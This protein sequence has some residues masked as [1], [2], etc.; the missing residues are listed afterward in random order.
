ML[1]VDSESPVYVPATAAQPWQHL[2]ARDGWERPPR[3]TDEQC[4]L[5]VQVMESWFLADRE[6]LGAYYGQGFRAGS[7]PQ[8]PLIEDVGKDDVLNG[9]EQATR[10]TSKGRYN[11]GRDSFDLLARLDPAKVTSASPYAKRF[12][13]ALTA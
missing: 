9:L 3:A 7:L 4:H 6:A 5:M 2:R 11:K 1:L 8:N 12:I 13:D 10:D